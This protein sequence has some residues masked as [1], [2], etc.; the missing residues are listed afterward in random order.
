MMTVARSILYS[1]AAAV[2]TLVTVGGRSD[3]VVVSAAD[4]HAVPA[5]VTMGSGSSLIDGDSSFSSGFLQ[6]LS[7]SSELPLPLPLSPSD[8]RLIVNDGERGEKVVISYEK[9]T[10]E[11]NNNNNNNNN[12]MLRSAST[13]ASTSA[14]SFSRLA[15]T[16]GSTSSGTS[17]VRKKAGGIVNS[18]RSSS[19]SSSNPNVNNIDIDQTISLESRQRLEETGRLISSYY[20]DKKHQRHSGLLPLHRRTQEEDEETI[21][22]MEKFDTCLVDV[23]IAVKQEPVCEFSG[24]TEL[25]CTN[26]ISRYVCLCLLLFYS[27]RVCDYV[28]GLN[29]G[30]REGPINCIDLIVMA[31]QVVSLRLLPFSTDAFFLT[32]FSV[33]EFW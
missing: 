15:A 32:F 1:S 27:R 17:L 19:S 21:A 14:S 25:T 22:R 28:G 23:D 7:P 29:K 31:D 6:L 12:M 2:A 20:L 11:N 18:T 13:S 26:D 10:K 30:F 24:A 3:L 5:A 33:A 16:S 4:E 8:R 9:K